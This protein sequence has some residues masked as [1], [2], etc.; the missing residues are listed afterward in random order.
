MIDKINNELVKKEIIKNGYYILENYLNKQDIEKIKNSLL[1]V[2]QYI[3]KD[4]EKDLLKKYYQIKKFNPKLKGNWFDIITSD[5][6]ILQYLYAPAIIDFVKEFFN[7]KVV[8]CGRRHLNVF[9]DENDKLFPPH[10]ETH[11]IARDTLL[12]WAPIYDTNKDNGGLAI[13]KNSHKHGYFKHIKQE[14]NSKNSKWTTGYNHVD[15]STQK[16][17][18]KLELEIKAGSALLMSSKLIHCSYP[19]KKKGKVRIV[20]T[21]RYNPLKKIPFLKNENAPMN[22]PFVGVDYNKISD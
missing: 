17:F 20:I 12:I 13:Y 10:Q 6:S 4:D 3:K 1:E 9:D 8:F 5:I 22:I 21:E 2:F 16:S 15:L 11:Q 19:T 18:E 14:A 7:T